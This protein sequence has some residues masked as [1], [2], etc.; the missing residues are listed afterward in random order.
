MVVTRRFLLLLAVGTSGL[1]WS[2]TGA[3]E[4]HGDVG[5]VLRPGAAEYDAARRVHRISGS[6]ENM[7]AA[8]DAFHYVWKKVS[9]NV[10]ITADISIL[11]TG[12][13]A[14]RKAALMI[15]QSLDADSAYADAALHGDGLASLQS[16]PEKGAATYEIQSA[17]KA[18]KR[19]RLVKRGDD[20]FLF[21][22][23]EGEELRFSGGS[24]PVRIKAPFYVGLAVCAHNKDRIETAEFSNVEIAPAAAGGPAR[25]TTLEAVPYPPGDRRALAASVEGM[26][27]PAWSADGQWIYF[28]SK[29]SGAMQVWRM[30]PDGTGTEQVTKDAMANW[31]PRPSPDGARLLVLSCDPSLAAPPATPEALL[32]VVTLIDGRVQTL[33]RFVTAAAAGAAWSPDGKR[34]VYLTEQTAPGK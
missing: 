8:T 1:L 17:A 24:V 28:N 5:V 19:L 3:F 11:G 21:V 7:W 23:G 10:T 6:G 2:Q 30:H 26:A 18:P 27:S 31:F 13:D 9:G 12:G 25:Y 33:A 32:R 4:G 22:A 34:V 14:H 16:R 20:F 29:R 15:R